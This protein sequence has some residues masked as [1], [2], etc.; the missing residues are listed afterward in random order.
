MANK[1]ERT[2]DG[3]EKKK[4]N[5]KQKTTTL[6]SEKKER[7]GRK[8]QRRAGQRLDTSDLPT[9]KKPFQE[10]RAQKQDFSG[11]LRLLSGMHH[12]VTKLNFISRCY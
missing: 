2:H 11:N 4:R 9:H 8:C 1:K 5:S 10:T 7:G 12:I 6:L 3:K